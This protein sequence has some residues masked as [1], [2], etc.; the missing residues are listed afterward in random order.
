MSSFDFR[1]SPNRCHGLALSEF[2]DDYV[3]FD[4]LL[5][6]GAEVALEE[7]AGGRLVLSEDAEFE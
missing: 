3:E 6:S 5:A 2:A 7:D 1:P 4:E